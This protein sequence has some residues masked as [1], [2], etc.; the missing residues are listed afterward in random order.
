MAISKLE[1]ADRLAAPDFISKSRPWL[2]QA[3][4]T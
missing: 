3:L 2:N 4:S 1:I